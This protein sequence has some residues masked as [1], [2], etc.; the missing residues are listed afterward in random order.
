MPGASR[1]GPSGWEHSAL[2]F[3][4]TASGFGGGPGNTPTSVRGLDSRIDPPSL[5]TLASHASYRWY[6]ESREKG[7]Y[8]A[9]GAGAVIV[10][11][12]NFDAAVHGASTLGV[13]YSVARTSHSSAFI[14]VTY[15]RVFGAVR[16]PSWLVP[17]F[18]GVKWTP[19]S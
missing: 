6:A 11:P 3:D 7:F 15:E 10:D 17:V 13:G 14:D 1:R 9:V 4:A 19:G 18:V 2:Q 5:A 12:S 16:A 8:V